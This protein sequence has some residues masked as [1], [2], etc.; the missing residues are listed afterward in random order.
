[1][2]EMQWKR[3]CCPVDFSDT[4]EAALH[5][6]V[7]LC[8]RFDA[9][10]T[11]LHVD[12]AGSGILKDTPSAPDQHLETWK[13]DAERLGAAHV[14]TDR[15][16][17][18][19]ALVIADYARAQGFD[20]IVMGTHGRTGRGHALVGSVAGSVIQRASCPV[21]TVSPSASVPRA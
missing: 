16:R 9:E 10:L 18:E 1:M 5:V 20:L 2:P 6:A 17:G 7:D 12:P 15:T 3:I 19:P 11:L 13:D 14:A 8:R 4:A 21:L